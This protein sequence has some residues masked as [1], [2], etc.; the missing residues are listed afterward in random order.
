MSVA[1]THHQVQIG[2]GQANAAMWTEWG[3]RLLVDMLTE[4]CGKN[5]SEVGG[6]SS[7]FLMSVGEDLWNRR[8]R[9]FLERLGTFCNVK[10]ISVSRQ[11]LTKSTMVM[12]GAMLQWELC[13]GI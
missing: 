11:L 4:E 13:K 1:T 9:W 7:L 6:Y 5:R 12:D 8:V 2:D 3:I 10:I